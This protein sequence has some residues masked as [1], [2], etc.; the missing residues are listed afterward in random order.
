MTLL[1][2]HLRG[3]CGGE[4][5]DPP[6]IPVEAPNT[7]QSKST[8]RMVDLLCEG[9]IAGLVD[10]AKSIY[11]DDVQLQ[12]DSGDYNFDGVTWEQRVGAPDQT[13]IKG[14]PAVETSIAVGVTVANGVPVTRT[15]TD[16]DVDAVRVHLALPSLWK[17][18]DN[19]DLK[20]SS[21]QFQIEV[22]GHS[23]TTKTVTDKFMSTYE[24]N[25]LVS[26][27]AGEAPWDIKIIKITED[28]PDQKSANT[29]NWAS[30]TEIINHKLTYPDSALIAGTVD[31]S[32]FGG[33]IPKRSYLIDGRII[34]VPSN[35]NPATRQYNGIWNGTFQLAWSDNPAWCFYDMLE[36]DRYGLGIAVPDKWALYPVAQYC[37][38]MVPDGFGGLGPRFTL[39][40]AIN[41][42]HEA[43]ALI[44]TLASAFQGMPVWSSG[45]VTVFQDA[46][47][48]P[49]LL[50]APANVKDGVF[51][52]EGTSRKSR[53]T[54]AYVTWNDPADRYKPCVE[55]VF[56]E[57]A[58]RKYGVRV[59]EVVAFGCTSRGMANRLGR[60]LTDTGDAEKETVTYLAGPDHAYAMPGWIV[61]VADPWVANVRMGGRLRDGFA[62]EVLGN[63][64]I[65]DISG[66][67]LVS[68]ATRSLS[69]AIAPDGSPGYAITDDSDA[70]YEY[71][72][73]LGY[74]SY[75]D[76]S[77]ICASA[78]VAKD[79]VDNRVCRL[80]AVGSGGTETF[81]GVCL[82]TNTGEYIQTKTSLAVMPLCLVV[83]CGDWWRVVIAGTIGGGNTSVAV[84]LHPAI[85][86][87]LTANDVAATGSATIAGATLKLM[88][89]TD[90]DLLDP[91]LTLR[92]D[93]SVTLADGETYTATV[94]M[95]D[96]AV[97][98]RSVTNAPGETDVL[99]L[100]AA[101]SDYPLANSMFVVTGTDIEPRLFRVL[102]KVENNDGW[103]QIIAAE[104]DRYKYAR[105]EQGLIIDTPSYSLPSSSGPVLPPNNPQLLLK[106]YY[107]DGQLKNMLVFAW[108]AAADD[109][110]VEYQVACRVD[111]GHWVAAP[112][113]AGFL[114]EKLDVQAGTW[115]FRV[116]SVTRTGGT[117]LWAVDDLAVSEATMPDVTGLVLVDGDTAATFTG[118]DARFAWDSVA[119]SE[120][121]ST[122]GTDPWF[123]SYIVEIWKGGALVRTEYPVIPEYVYTFEKNTADSG[124]DRAFEIKVYQLGNLGQI[125][126]SPAT[127]AVSN[128]APSMAGFIPPVT[129]VFKGL[130]IDWSAWSSPDPDLR[131]IKVYLDT[132]PTPTTMVA[133]LSAEAIG[134]T[135]SGLVVGM[136]YQVLLVPGDAF[137]DG[138]ASGA[139]SGTPLI[140]S[141]VDVDME[142]T[143]SIVMSDSLDT[144]A[145]TLATLYDR[146]TTSGG[147]VRTLGGA[148]QWIQYQF[149]MITYIDKV[150]LHL[151]DANAR[152]YFAYSTDG[153]TWSWLAAE[154]DHT[155]DA[156]GRLVTAASQL[157]AQG[158]YLQLDAG[159]NVA[160]FPQRV[161]A[162][163]C[164]LYLTGTYTTTIYEL[165]F[166]REV[167]AEQVVADNLSAISANLGAVTAGY[168]QSTNYTADTGVKFDLD[169]SELHLGGSSGGVSEPG[170]RFMP[171]YGL[172]IVGDIESHDPDTIDYS[173]LTDGSLEF[174]LWDA[175]ASTYR[176]YYSAKQ[177]TP[178]QATS[179]TLVT[180][181]GYWRDAPKV[182][183]TA[184]DIPLYDASYPAADQKMVVSV[185][186]PAETSAGSHQWR[187]TVRA[188][189]QL[190]SYTFTTSWG[191]ETAFIH[192]TSVGSW[193]YDTQSTTTYTVPANTVSL[194]VS[195]HLEWQRIITIPT[196]NIY[197]SSSIEVYFMLAGVKTTIYSATYTFHSGIGSSIV[198]LNLSKTLTFA[199]GAP[200][201]TLVLYVKAGALTTYSD[202]PGYMGVAT[203]G[204][205]TSNRAA[206]TIGAAA[207]LATGKV[208]AVA[209]GG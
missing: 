156:A 177:V 184:I 183:A 43:Y 126:N 26:L 153:E 44:N 53:H 146:N 27:P 33:R 116:R 45:S 204:E 86:F 186:T 71:A 70:A 117:S 24:V 206:G 152:A 112:K 94:T 125:S 63:N 149:G 88:S 129:A 106:T 194:T 196:V 200:T 51:S 173:R 54:V 135:E 120:I 193:V 134:Y 102:S 141:G 155:L 166:V 207:V 66:W 197:G 95:P 172:D 101:L 205:L 83:D 97:E 13:Y 58:I 81:F 118:G 42:A 61:A 65:N 169:N 23:V 11:L 127:I 159:L 38:E 41:T 114:F 14:F 175:A 40:C 7:A 199:A 74:E 191:T 158:A 185:D 188:E 168:L 39:N 50:V 77:P 1:L 17:Q 55:P 111:D 18:Y 34:K 128:P 84:S 107:A 180:I 93:A 72:C 163:Y 170:M 29:V 176:K 91:R 2:D 119:L 137:G 138:V 179:G 64:L 109:R 37:D 36:H 48:D 164:R 136:D 82:K 16:S 87:I 79:D 9:E 147:L 89:G 10:G 124:P 133:K 174:F 69:G 115:Y 181:P 90:Y 187:T 140:L 4:E 98:Q 3:S 28:A 59:K 96:G 203:Q 62:A 201:K 150:I 121:A 35:Y 161:T 57:A 189:L 80:I 103:R 68:G 145:A 12:A 167:I 60:W 52:Y 104:H 75:I 105:I 157:A 31:S 132:N 190:G 108:E 198:N 182:H 178:F 160:V 5:P 99:S 131:Y 165:V 195:C 19:G 6:Y 123:K 46:P 144:P 78:F 110:V 122:G 15:I 192:A 143:E 171:G 139:G 30:Y 209:F 47:A 100:A 142:L 8:W 113:L 73:S 92:L 32:L 148:D 208:H 20:G 22:V 130:K 162:Q 85:G 25:Y 56:N 49:Q 154:A 151:A 202:I 67:Q 21:V 76:G